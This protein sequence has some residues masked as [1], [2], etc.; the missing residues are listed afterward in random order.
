[1]QH[2]S[3]GKINFR[4]EGGRDGHQ[5]RG[6]QHPGERLASGHPRLRRL[7]HRGSIRWS[8]GS[9]RSSAA[10]STAACSARSKPSPPH[11]RNGSSSGTT[12]PGLSSG[13]RAPTTSSTRSAATATESHD[14]LTSRKRSLTWAFACPRNSIISDSGRQWLKRELLRVTLNYG[15]Y[16]WLCA[17]RPI[18]SCWRGQLSRIFGL[19]RAVTS[20]W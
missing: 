12:P 7:T 15:E 10:A 8:G 17:G 20:G 16:A 19:T 9:P 3:P 11:C 1:M 18:P 13:P 2:P 4:G 6:R 14:R 5:E